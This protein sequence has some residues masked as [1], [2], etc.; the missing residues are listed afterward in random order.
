MLEISALSCGFTHEPILRNIS[1]RLQQG[2]IAC[3]L[4]AS[5][6]GKTALLF[7]IAGFIPVHHGSISYA[8]ELLSISRKIRVPTEKRNFGFVFQESALFPH[9]TVQD[10]IL[11]GLYQRPVHERQHLLGQMLDI[12][13]LKGFERRLPH[14]LSGGQKQRVA[15]ARALAPHPRLLL[16]DEP[17]AGL[18]AELR[19]QL[20]FEL[21]TAL[22]ASN[23]TALFVTH[24]KAEAVN[25]GD[26]LGFLEA[27]GIRHWGSKF[28][29][30]DLIMMDTF[31]TLP[32]EKKYG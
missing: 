9:L 23:H 30:E 12:L 14:Q 27:D 3:I 11:F 20:S 8:K 21:R 6:I 31:A 32:H 13:H 5:G 26:T 7:T 28:D 4:G 29:L 18:D 2:E 10:N 24:D 19:R 25:V 1:F 22:K 15:I 17:F 16:L